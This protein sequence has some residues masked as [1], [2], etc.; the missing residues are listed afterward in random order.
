MAVVYI[1]EVF[2]V[3]NL[4][5]VLQTSKTSMK[6]TAAGAT[7]PK[8][9][10]PAEKSADASAAA[11]AAIS[12]KQRKPSIK[13]KAADHTAAAAHGRGSAAVDAV[14]PSVASLATKA[15]PVSASQTGGPAAGGP[16]A[17]VAGDAGGVGKTSKRKREGPV[18]PR[19]AKDIYAAQHREQVNF[20]R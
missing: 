18:F 1:C 16:P 14:Q 11:N 20:P 9:A 4:Q 13:H 19:S 10:A 2:A 7:A 5:T 15:Q 3:H 12:G 6:S 8:K 17:G